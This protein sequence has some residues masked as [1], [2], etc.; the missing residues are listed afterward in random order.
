MLREEIKGSNFGTPTTFVK[1]SLEIVAP[2]KS[3]WLQTSLTLSNS[4]RRSKLRVPEIMKQ[5]GKNE[6]KFQIF[7]DA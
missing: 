7:K 4:Q 5:G 2:D 6:V 1:R 3:N